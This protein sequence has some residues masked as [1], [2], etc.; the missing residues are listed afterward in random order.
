MTKS[1]ATHSI[2]SSSHWGSTRL[3]CTSISSSMSYASSDSESNRSRCVSGYIT[4]CEYLSHV[5]DQRAYIRVAH[6]CGPCCVCLRQDKTAPSGYLPA[7]CNNYNTC[8]MVLAESRLQGTARCFLATTSQ[9]R[10]YV[11]FTITSP[12]AWCRTGF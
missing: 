7:D 6:A 2:R 3:A 12:A 9:H 5:L 10:L 8:S 11:M 4:I 1:T